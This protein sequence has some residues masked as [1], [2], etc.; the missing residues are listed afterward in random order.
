MTSE[1]PGCGFVDD[2]TCGLHAPSWRT[3]A[4]AAWAE[5]Y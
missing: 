3:I 4:V 2:D 1:E 5:R